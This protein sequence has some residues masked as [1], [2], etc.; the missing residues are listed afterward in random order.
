M[1]SSYD[2]MNKIDEAFAEANN[3]IYLNDSSDYCSALFEVCRI[4][5]PELNEEIGNQYIGED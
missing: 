4:L 1:G 3:A 2:N 5:K